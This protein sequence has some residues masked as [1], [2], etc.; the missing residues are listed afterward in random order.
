M[1]QVRP[2]SLIEVKPPDRILL[3][4]DIDKTNTGSKIRMQPSDP[5][6]NN[7]CTETL[8]PPK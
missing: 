6:I 2:Q 4:E 7:G 3:R 1:G 5:R 8:P